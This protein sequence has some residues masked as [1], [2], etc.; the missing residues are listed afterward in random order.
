MGAKYVLKVKWVRAETL[1]RNHPEHKNYFGVEILD[2]RP[3]P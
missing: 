3:I 2:T 1:G